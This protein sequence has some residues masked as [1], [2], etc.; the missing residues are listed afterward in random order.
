MRAIPRGAPR[1]TPE[2]RLRM[3]TDAAYPDT[4]LLI[5]NQ[6]R[7]ATGGKTLEV[8]NPA[9]GER[10]GRVAHASTA[11]L[12]LALAAAQRGFDTWRWTPAAPG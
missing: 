4:R 9:T 12:D 6:W 5:D 8:L 10:I 11:D 2:T 1:A 7:D 3:T